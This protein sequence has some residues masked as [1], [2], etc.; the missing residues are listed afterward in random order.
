MV[1]DRYGEKTAS[2]LTGDSEKAGEG[3][4]VREGVDLEG[5]L[6]KG[7][8]S[9]QPD[10]FL[11]KNFVQSARLTGNNLVDGHRCLVIRTRMWGRAGARVG[12]RR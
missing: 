8:T 7:C 3:G 5:D 4:G 1:A 10:L 12:G 9:R 2:C 6:V 11:P